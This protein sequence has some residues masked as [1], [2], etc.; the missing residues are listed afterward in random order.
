[1]KKGFYII[2]LDK[3][4]NGGTHWTAFYF[5]DNLQSLYFDSYGFLAPEEVEKQIKPYVFNDRQIQDY[6]SSS[7]GYFVIAFIYFLSKINQDI[8][9]SFK[10][11]INLFYKD[12]E[13][14]E[15]LLNELLDITY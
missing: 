5:D 10:C 7:C 3:A 11:F 13:K 12:T 6:N 4:V 9:T 15:E 14:N 1:M 8:E 2:N